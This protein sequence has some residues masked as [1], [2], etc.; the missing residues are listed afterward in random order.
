[1]ADSLKLKSIKADATNPAAKPANEPEPP[2]GIFS[3]E[4]LQRH[5][6]QHLQKIPP[7]HRFAVF[8]YY[9]TDG[10]AIFTVVARPVEGWTI[11]AVLTQAPGIG[12]SGGAWVQAS[13]P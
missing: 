5:I 3:P 6:D 4:A 7:A 12:L 1:M 2:L 10:T 8:G 11:G 13:W 9:A